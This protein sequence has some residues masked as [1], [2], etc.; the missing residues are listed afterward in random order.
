M[1]EYTLNYLIPQQYLS[2]FLSGVY[3]LIF[4]LLQLNNQ[5]NG[6]IYRVIK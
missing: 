5:D 4:S 6:N 3:C 1:G 2:S